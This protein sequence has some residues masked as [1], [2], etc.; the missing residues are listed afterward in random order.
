MT[1]LSVLRQSETLAWVDHLSLIKVLAG[2]TNALWIFRRACQAN[3]QTLSSSSRP[4]ETTTAL[5]NLTT[6][7]LA[8]R[9]ARFFCRGSKKVEMPRTMRNK[10]IFRSSSLQVLETA[11]WVTAMG[12]VPKKNRCFELYFLVIGV[13]SSLCTRPKI[14]SVIQIFRVRFIFL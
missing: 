10:L 4:T 3:N 7:R 5:G 2:S 13:A 14:N 12:Q 8:I 1:S 11:I 6:Y 9:L